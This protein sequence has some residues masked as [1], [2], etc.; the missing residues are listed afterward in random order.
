M[1]HPTYLRYQLYAWSGSQATFERLGPARKRKG[2]EDDLALLDIERASSGYED[3]PPPRAAPEPRKR[4]SR[5]VAPKAPLFSSDWQLPS[6]Q[7]KQKG[8]QR[9]LQRSASANVPP[10][11]ALDRNG[12]PLKPVAVGSRK[13]FRVDS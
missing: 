12:K 6:A 9:T 11:L 2:S 8:V 1:R 13:R 4:S 7:V 10:P 5:S 3:D